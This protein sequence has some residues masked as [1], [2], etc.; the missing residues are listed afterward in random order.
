M[1]PRSSKHPKVR[2]KRQLPSHLETPTPRSAGSRSVPLGR[3]RVYGESE[4][5]LRQPT[6]RAVGVPIRDDIRVNPD[7]LVEA[8]VDEHQHGLGL[9]V[10]AGQSQPLSPDAQTWKTLRPF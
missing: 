4:R 3:C 9:D 1:A 2:V 8:L 5:L 10:P 6:E 7:N